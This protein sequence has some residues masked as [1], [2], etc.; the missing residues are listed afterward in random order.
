MRKQK[1]IKFIIKSADQLRDE[2]ILLYTARTN[3]VN[4][5]SQ[6]LKKDGAPAD[7]EDPGNKKYLRTMADLYISTAAHALFYRHLANAFGFNDN[8]KFQPCFTAIENL[9]N[10]LDE[11]AEEKRKTIT[12]SGEMLAVLEPEIRNRATN[13]S[14]HLFQYFTQIKP[15]PKQQIIKKINGRGNFKKFQK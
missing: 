2:L 8:Q 15:K 9:F 7:P 12:K 3:F 10:A 4:T 5:I 6:N 1:P 13:C 11:F 14:K